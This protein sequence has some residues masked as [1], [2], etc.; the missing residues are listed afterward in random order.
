MVWTFKKSF[1][2]DVEKLGDFFPKIWSPWVQLQHNFSLFKNVTDSETKFAFT[3]IYMTQSF[4]LIAIISCIQWKGINRKQSTRWQHLS[5][6]KASAFFSLQN[7]L[8]VMKHS[9]L[10]LGL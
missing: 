4:E 5:W 7:F 10:H 1:D 8:V 3:K 2:V 6:L 9:N